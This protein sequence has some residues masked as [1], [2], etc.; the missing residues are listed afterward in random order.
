MVDLPLPFAPTSGSH[1]EDGR[2]VVRL[3]CPIEVFTNEAGGVT[4]QQD[5][6][7]WMGDTVIVVMNDA[8]TVR[9]VI[10]ALQREIGDID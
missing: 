4:I 5:Q 8:P 1:D 2:L 7:G 3:Q 9:A 10:R 6:P